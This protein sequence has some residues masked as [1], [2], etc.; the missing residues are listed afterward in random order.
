MKWYN[1][2]IFRFGKNTLIHLLISPNK[3]T[4]CLA[5][6]YC[7]IEGEGKTLLNIGIRGSDLVVAML[8]LEAE[9]L[10]TASVKIGDSLLIELAESLNSMAGGGSEDMELILL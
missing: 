4:K 9:E 10:L 5:A 1:L 3:Q 8:A 6:D 7:C 2:D